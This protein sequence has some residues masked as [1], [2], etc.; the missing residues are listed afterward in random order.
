VYTISV[1][2]ANGTIQVTHGSHTTTAPVPVARDQLGQIARLSGGKAFT[3]SDTA[4][5]SAA[6][7]GLAAR[8][9]KKTVKQEITTSFAGVALVLLVLGSLFSLLWFGRLI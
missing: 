2:T 4:G 1:G 5:L 3:A 7:Q 6:Y 8:L 9:G